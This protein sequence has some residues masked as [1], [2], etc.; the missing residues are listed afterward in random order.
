MDLCGYETL[1]RSSTRAERLPERHCRHLEARH[2][3]GSC[4]DCEAEAARDRVALDSAHVFGGADGRKLAVLCPRDPD[5]TDHL[6]E[7]GVCNG[8][9]Y[10]GLNSEPLSVAPRVRP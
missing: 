7:C 8:F 9:G 10:L 4:L 1:L 5:V 2:V 6:T 3:R